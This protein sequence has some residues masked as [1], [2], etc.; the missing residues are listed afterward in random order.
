MS[1]VVKTTLMLRDLDDYAAMRATELA[2]YRQHAP[3]LVD[4]PP[5]STF[6]QVPAIGD[7]P[8]RAIS[9]R[10]DWSGVGGIG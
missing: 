1:K 10:R 7:D 2:Y 3:S 5:A 6:M 4:Y 8:A 9:N